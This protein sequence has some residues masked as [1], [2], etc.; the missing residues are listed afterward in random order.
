MMVSARL[1]PG[2]QRALPPNL[3][4]CKPP[5]AFGMGQRRPEFTVA[6]PTHYSREDWFRALSALQQLLLQMRRISAAVEI[7]LHFRWVPAAMSISLL[8]GVAETYSITSKA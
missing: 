6:T 3:G 2:H 5:L 8:G 4:M 1:Y 7:P